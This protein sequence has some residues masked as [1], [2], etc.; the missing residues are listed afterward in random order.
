MGT[1]WLSLSINGT[2]ID[3]RPSLIIEEF[4]LILRRRVSATFDISML[5]IEAAATEGLI[6]DVKMKPGAKLLI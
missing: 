1:I 5:L 3:L 4:S 2:F 6:D